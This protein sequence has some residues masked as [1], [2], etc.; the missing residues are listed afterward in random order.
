MT[1]AVVIGDVTKFRV[2]KCVG[3]FLPSDGRSG[4]QCKEG[5]KGSELC[6]C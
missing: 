5:V 3:I 6:H 2:V 1:P 4:L